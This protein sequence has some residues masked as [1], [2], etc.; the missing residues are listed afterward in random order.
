MRL[1]PGKKWQKHKPWQ[2]QHNRCSAST[3][4]AFWRL[5][6]HL[7]HMHLMMLLP[8]PPPPPPPLELLLRTRASKWPS[9]G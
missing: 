3:A 1:Q 5:E 6:L 9:A 2:E 4:R 8:P 7:L